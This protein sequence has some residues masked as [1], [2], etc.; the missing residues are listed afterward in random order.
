MFS[1]PL[2]FVSFICLLARSSFVLLSCDSNAIVDKDDCL[3]ALHQIVYKVDNTLDTDSKRFSYIYGNCSIAVSNAYGASATRNEVEN[4]F[5]RIFDQCAPHTGAGTV[6][7][8]KNLFLSV[9]NGLTGGDAPYNSDFLFLKPTC[10]LNKNAPHTTKEDCLKYSFQ[11]HF[12]KDFED[13]RWAATLNYATLAISDSA[14]ATVSRYVSRSAISSNLEAPTS[15]VVDIAQDSDEE[16]SKIK[17]KRQRRDPFEDPRAF[18]SV[19]FHRKDDPES[20]LAQTHTCL[21]CS[22]ELRA[23]GSSLSNLCTHRDG[24]RQTGRNSYGFPKRQE[25]ITAG[26]KLPLTVHEEETLKISETCGTITNYFAPTAKFDNGANLFKRKWAANSAREVY[27]DLQDAMLKRLKDAKS[28]FS[29]I[30]DVWTTKGNRFGFIGASV[31]FI[32]NEWQYVVLHLTLKLVAWYHKG[33]LLAEPII[34]TTDSGSNNNT[35]AETMHTKLRDINGSV[36]LEWDYATMHIKCVCHKMALVV[37]AG[38]NELGLQ[39]PLPSK[40]RKAFLGSFPYINTMEKIVKESEDEAVGLNM[41]EG[42]DE[43]DDDNDSDD[44]NDDE[45]DMIEEQSDTEAEQS[46]Q[47]GNSQIST[48]SVTNRNSQNQTK[49]ATNRNSSNE[50]NELTKAARS[51]VWRQE[52]DRQAKVFDE[53]EGGK[54]LKGLIAGYGIRWNIKYQSRKRAY[55]A[56]EV[57]DSMLHDEYIKY[58]DQI[59]RSSRQENRKKLGHFKEIQFTAKDWMMIDELNQELKPFNRLTKI[60]E[61]DGP[62]GAFVLPNYYQ[63]IAD[64]K[65]KEEACDRGHAFHP[66]FV[67]MIDKLQVYQDEALN[68]ETLEKAIPA[69]QLLERHFSSQDKIMKNQKSNGKEKSTQTTQPINKENIFELFNAPPALDKNEELEAYIKNIDHTPGPS[70][71]DPKSVLVWW[72]DHSSNYPVLAS[73]AKDYLASSASSF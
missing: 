47:S 52:F 64:L 26:A 9:G 11:Q 7:A 42:D 21:W 22:K 29:L 55:K 12:W 37:N 71:K 31:S 46:N 56:R 73:L 48:K 41:N 40:L 3:R 67:K 58:Q 20:K 50:L 18:F 8:A 30:H 53:R 19:P 60:M 68:C 5:I 17:H 6:P 36:E 69:Q 34:N 24:S 63:I 51:C 62:T 2:V 15:E 39:A 13:Q 45:D 54:P 14:A 25:A 35:M 10:G 43:S 49:S 1:N 57:L 70:A 28:K 38:L 65:R 61:G 32:D 59:V 23:S 72:K 16:N 4:A 33:S 44:L 27:L 66:M